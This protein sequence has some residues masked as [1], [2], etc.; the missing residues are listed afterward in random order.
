MSMKLTFKKG[1]QEKQQVMYSGRSNFNQSQ[2]IDLGT[3]KI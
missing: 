3:G 2:I 1:F